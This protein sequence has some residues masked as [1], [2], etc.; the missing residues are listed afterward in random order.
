MIKKFAW[1]LSPLLMVTLSC[2][3][4]SFAGS[5]SAA[6]S[7]GNFGS[8]SNTVFTVPNVGN[9]PDA[10][11]FRTILGEIPDPIIVDVIVEGRTIST[12]TFATF[13]TAYDYLVSVIER[14]D[15]NEIITVRAGT[16][17]ITIVRQFAQA[18]AGIKDLASTADSSLTVASLSMNRG[19]GIESSQIAQ[20]E[21]ATNTL[22]F[23]RENEKVGELTIETNPDLADVASIVAAISFAAG[24]DLDQVGTASNMVLAG[25]DP[26]STAYLMLA[27]RKIQNSDQVDIRVVD[28]AINTFNDIV[29]KGNLETI[30]ALGDLPGF[31]SIR[32]TLVAA[33]LASP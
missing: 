6:T 2:P 13:E 16:A 30:S 10:D 8:Y 12:E 4:P 27:M 26:D 11:F 31:L 25:A 33:S 5:T 29:N 19:L 22:T 28:F 23:E 18:S 9:I 32:E 7:G 1:A 14:A 15:P 17:T 24:I 21:T 3:Q 20:S